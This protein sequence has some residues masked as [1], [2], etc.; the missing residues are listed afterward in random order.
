[1]CESQRSK[2]IGDALLEDLGDYSV[3][4]DPSSTDTERAT[5]Q[6][7]KCV[8][9]FK[10]ETVKLATNDHR[11][12]GYPVQAWVRVCTCTV[13][14]QVDGDLSLCTDP[15]GARGIVQYF[16]VSPRLCHQLPCVMFDAGSIGVK[17]LMREKMQT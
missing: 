13:A 12:L 16:M 15:R 14:D 17:Y 9:N 3:N 10:S 4:D 8:N 7:Q 11:V 2:E 6:W 1:M 5:Y